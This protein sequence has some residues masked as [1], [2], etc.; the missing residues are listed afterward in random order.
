MSRKPS[1]TVQLKLRFPEKLRQRIESAAA[2]NK[3]SM[4]GEIVQRLEQSFQKDDLLAREAT[5]AQAAA[6]TAL[7]QFKVA[8]EG[9]IDPV[10]T[11]KK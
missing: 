5:V 7:E 10:G 8:S 2:G 11:I 9:K 1:Q 6:T 4:N 3:R